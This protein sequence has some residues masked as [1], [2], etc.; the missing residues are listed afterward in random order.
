MMKKLVGA[1]CICLLACLNL[2]AAQVDT[3]LVRS[4]SMNK[5]IKIVAIR[6]DKA[7]KGEKCPV[8]YLLHGHG[9]D[10]TKWVNKT[11]PKLPQLANQYGIILVCPNGERSW[12]F[13]SYNDTKN[14]FETYVSKE[15]VEYVDKNYKTIRSP[16]ARAITGFSMG[17]HGALWLAFR[18]QDV[19]GA[20]GS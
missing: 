14:Q 6:P 11:Q 16:H 8:I 13:D 9:D 7:M 2:Q 17:G 20:C 18:H 19:F 15:L 10:H 4:E 12:Y 3:L 1:V 5:D